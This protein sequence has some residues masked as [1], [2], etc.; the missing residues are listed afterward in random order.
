MSGFGVTPAEL[1]ETRAFVGAAAAHAR[2]SVEGL[3]AA[4]RPVLTEQW[5]GE[6]AAAFRLAWEQWWGGAVLVLDALDELARLTGA[7]GDSYAGTD[8]AV[9]VRIARGST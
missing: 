3:H 2:R 8:E 7:A 4:A 6:A 5:Q 9:R 1:A